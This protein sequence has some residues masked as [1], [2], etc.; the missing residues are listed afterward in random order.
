MT[1]GPKHQS[2]AR[3]RGLV[4]KEDRILFWSDSPPIAKAVEKCLPLL[5]CLGWNRTLVVGCEC[6]S[7]LSTEALDARSVGRVVAWFAADRPASFHTRAVRR[8]REQS[9]F[10]GGF[11]A[12]VG[13]KRRKEAL[14]VQ[15]LFGE[16]PVRFPFGKIPGHVCVAPPVTL[17]K[18]LVAL[19]TVGEM[20]LETW[21]DIWDA[22]QFG[23]IERQMEL[24]DVSMST[25]DLADVQEEL[26]RLG[27][28]LMALNW[29]PHLPQR[30]L[31]MVDRVL[32]CGPKPTTVSG[33]RRLLGELRNVLKLMNG[34]L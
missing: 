11:V 5:A 14:D 29:L 16:K 26:R 2:G 34:W 24:L 20:H 31:E 8:L 4:R 19:N 12:V 17:P 1:E 6:G 33:C 9:Q 13:S 23:R 27:D 22:S 32:S 25:T 7:A 21:Y 18:L 15:C 3:E 28:E 30:D 10:E